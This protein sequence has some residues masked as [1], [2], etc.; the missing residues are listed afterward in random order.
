MFVFAFLRV[1]EIGSAMVTLMDAPFRTT[2]SRSR[3]DLRHLTPERVTNATGESFAQDLLLPCWIWYTR[4]R[5]DDSF[6]CHHVSVDRKPQSSR[7]VAQADRVLGWMS[8]SPVRRA[9]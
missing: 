1:S 3:R 6:H 8:A 2:A 5:Y 4:L 7:T 9:P